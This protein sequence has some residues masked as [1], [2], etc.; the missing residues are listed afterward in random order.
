MA[1]PVSA[2]DGLR[3]LRTLGQANRNAA[4]GPYG[5]FVQP[6]GHRSFAVRFTLHRR[7]S[8]F[9]LGDFAPPAFGI[10]AARAAAA[11]AM[12]HV[13]AGTAP[14]TARPK[15]RLVPNGDFL[16]NPFSM[17]ASKWVAELQHPTLW[18]H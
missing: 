2:I 6:S 8:K 4:S 1:Y 7:F 11:K 15:P 16:T 12:E 14:I 5:T 9:T 17:K 10:V 13:I 3:C 18:P